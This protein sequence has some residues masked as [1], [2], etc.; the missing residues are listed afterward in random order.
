MG[1]RDF[2]TGGVLTGLA[3]MLLLYP[4]AVWIFRRTREP[5]PW[6]SAVGLALGVAIANFFVYFFFIVALDN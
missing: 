6:L 3:S 5:R 4:W 1:N 2:Q